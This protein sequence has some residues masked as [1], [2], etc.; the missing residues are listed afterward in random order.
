MPGLPTG[1]GG[2]A[3]PARPGPVPFG[4]AWEAW[5][6]PEADRQ[7]LFVDGFGTEPVALRWDAGGAGD[8]GYR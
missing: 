3:P 2:L 6:I 5:G 4:G 1:G 7:S 8:C